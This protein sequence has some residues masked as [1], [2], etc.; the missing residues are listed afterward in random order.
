[1]LVWPSVRRSPDIFLTV[2]FAALTSKSD[3]PE[4]DAKPKRSQV[5]RNL[6]TQDAR[7]RSH[8]SFPVGTK[9]RQVA[10][11]YNREILLCP[12][13]ENANSSPVSEETV[14]IQQPDVPGYMENFQYVLFKFDEGLTY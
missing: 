6:T 2:G 3:V 7:F 1:M 11:A 8:Y 14:L 4:C 10:Y 13:R 9:Y 5:N 12:T